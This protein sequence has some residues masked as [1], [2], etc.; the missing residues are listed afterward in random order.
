MQID[1]NDPSGPFTCL[2]WDS[3]AILHF[4]SPPT[5]PGARSFRPLRNG[6]KAT[7][8]WCD[9]EHHARL[10]VGDDTADQSCSIET[11]FT[12]ENHSSLRS[13]PIRSP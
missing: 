11:A 3:V 1:S 12:I 6:G 4:T 7:S 2:N 8:L 10:T 5:L 13:S 9:V